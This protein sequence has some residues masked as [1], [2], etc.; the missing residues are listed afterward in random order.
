MYFMTNMNTYPK[1][2]KSGVVQQQEELAKSK[3]PYSDNMFFNF[4]DM[5]KISEVMEA[6]NITEYTARSLIRSGE[7]RSKMIRGSYRV[8]KS[9]LY[10]FTYGTAQQ[11]TQSNK[12]DEQPTILYLARRAC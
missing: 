10:E 2:Y 8:P 3:S 9:S 1:G 6:L 7:L 4:P 12:A 11:P 5:L